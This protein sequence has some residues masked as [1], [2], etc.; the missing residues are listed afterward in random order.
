MNK[1]PIDYRSY[2]G[3][4]KLENYN[5]KILIITQENIVEFEFDNKLNPPWLKYYSQYIMLDRAGNIVKES[6]SFRVIIT[7]INQ[8][9]FKLPKELR[10]IRAPYIA[11]MEDLG[12]F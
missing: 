2:R 12:P 7:L 11:I 4:L 8:D 5:Y 6:N 3:F 1:Y 10:N 9:F